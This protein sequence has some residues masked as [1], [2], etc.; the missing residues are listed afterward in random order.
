MKIKIIFL[1]FDG[2]LNSQESLDSRAKETGQWPIEWIDTKLIARVNQIVEAT[3]AQVVISSSW[4]LYYELDWLINY[5]NQHGFVGTVIDRTPSRR[6][7]HDIRMR[8]RGDEIKEWMDCFDPK[9]I[10]SFVIL[11]D[12]ADMNQLLP[13]LVQTDFEVG[14]TEENVQKAIEM[15]NATTKP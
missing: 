15:L 12:D 10:E 7:L 1:D 4:R 2:V 3:G 11:D 6:D 9:D 14:L 13:Y 8:D 5:L